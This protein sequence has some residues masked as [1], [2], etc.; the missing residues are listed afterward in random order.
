[1]DKVNSVITDKTY[2]PLGLII[3]FIG[4]TI[5]MTVLATRLQIAV[6]DHEKRINRVENKI[7]EMPTAREINEI[8]GVLKS[9]K[10]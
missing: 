3:T 1:M 10:N 9:Q 5:S 4:V 7:D 6:S 2:L 8:I